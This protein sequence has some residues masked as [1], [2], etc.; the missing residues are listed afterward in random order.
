MVGFC[1]KL[2]VVV[3]VSGVIIRVSINIV[4]VGLFDIVICFVGYGVGSEMVRWFL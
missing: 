1:C 3:K 2:F 4:D